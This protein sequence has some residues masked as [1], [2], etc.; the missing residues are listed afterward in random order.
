MLVKIELCPSCADKLRKIADEQGK[1]A[2]GRACGPTVQACEIC[3]AQLPERD[4]KLVTRMK[5]HNRLDE[6]WSTD[7]IADYYAAR[8]GKY[9][10]K[11]N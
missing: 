1:D 4:G 8:S 6:G 5:Y 10:R 7:D 11:D 2:V 3:R 9:F